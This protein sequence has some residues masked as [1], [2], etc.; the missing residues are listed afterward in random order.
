MTRNE[1]LERYSRQKAQLMRHRDIED[2]QAGGLAYAAFATKSAFDQS[3]AFRGLAHA[4]KLFNIAAA[5]VI[6][7]LLVLYMMG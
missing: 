3:P 6:P 7:I 5:G 2:G 4:A 1:M